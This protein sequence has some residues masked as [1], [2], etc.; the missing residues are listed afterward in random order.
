MSMGCGEVSWSISLLLAIVCKLLGDLEVCL[1]AWMVGLDGNSS[2]R[3][4]SIKGGRVF[5]RLEH[6]D[7]VLYCQRS[8]RF[9]VLVVVIQRLSILRWQDAEHLEIGIEPVADVVDRPE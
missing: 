7:P 8:H 4:L 2:V 6:T 1:H 9:Q 3:L 5:H